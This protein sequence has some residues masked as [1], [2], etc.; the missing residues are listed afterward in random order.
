MTSSLREKTLS[1][2]VDTAAVQDYV[3]LFQN[4]G[5][6]I[7]L[8]NILGKYIKDVRITAARH[9]FYQRKKARNFEKSEK[10]KPKLVESD[11]IDEHLED[12]LGISVFLPF[13]SHFCTYSQ[14]T[15]VTDA[16][17]CRGVNIQSYGPFFDV[18][19]NTNG[20]S[21][22]RRLKVVRFMECRIL[23]L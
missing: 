10:F 21:T 5:H 3:A 18:L 23:G 8:E 7:K 1:R 13:A 16:A 6:Q 15:M 9:I 14:N 11:H 19:F 2:D 12:Y 20:I 22:L 17:H 4:Y